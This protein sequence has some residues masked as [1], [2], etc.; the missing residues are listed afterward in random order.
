MRA[1]NALYIYPGKDPDRQIQ[2]DKAL[3]SSD[4]NGLHRF[5]Q[6]KIYVDG[7][8]SQ[9]TAR[10]LTPYAVDL[11]L[12]LP[13]DTGFAYFDRERLYRYAREFSESG[14]SFHF[15]ATGELGVRAA[16]DAIEQ[17]PSGSGPHR[18]THVYR[19]HPAD[20]ERFGTL[21]VYADFQI[22]PSAQ[23]MS[24]QRYIAKLLGERAPDLMPLTALHAAGAPITLSSDWDADELSPLVKLATVLT[25]HPRL[26]R[27]DVF[28][29]MTVNGATLLRHADRTGSLEVGKAADLVIIDG[30]LLNAPAA[31]IAGSAVRATLLQGQAVFDP[32]GL[33]E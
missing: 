23:S 32:D 7:I 11:G 24:Y 8:L 10:T 18:I 31:E 33:F 5:D 4:P 16:L 28:D 3:H 20:R 17:L 26:P 29:M 2:D 6:V 1:S 13:G 25:H 21:G 12:P 22:A 9:T 15:H 30:D 14:V 27:K 19:V